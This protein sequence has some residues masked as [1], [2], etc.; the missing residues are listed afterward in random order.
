MLDMP[1]SGKDLIRL[2]KQQGW[3]VVR[4]N[5]SHHILVKDDR[6][7]VVPVHG[8]RSLGRGLESKILK[9]ARVKK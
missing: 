5:G 7:V 1:L 6:T 3:E 9:Q 8:N 2:L 4:V